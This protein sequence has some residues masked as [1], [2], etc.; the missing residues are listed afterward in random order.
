MVTDLTSGFQDGHWVPGQQDKKHVAGMVSLCRRSALVGGG[1]GCCRA[2]VGPAGHAKVAVEVGERFGW[3]VG[4]GPSTP[5]RSNTKPATV[6]STMA[7]GDDDA[8]QR[9]PAAAVVHTSAKAGADQRPVVARARI[10][11][12]WWRDRGVAG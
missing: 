7:W 8:K 4:S 1:D 11:A 2:A 3:L 5:A 10:N 12:Q 6:A 9:Q